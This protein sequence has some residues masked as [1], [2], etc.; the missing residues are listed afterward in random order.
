MLVFVIIVQRH[1]A[2]IHCVFGLM[3]G[4]QMPAM[5]GDNET[6][7]LL[8]SDHFENAIAGRWEQLKFGRPTEYFICHEANSNCLKA[9]AD[10]TC[11]ALMTKVQLEPRPRLIARWRWK[12]DQ[13]P[14]NS[15]DHLARSFDHTARV[16]IAFDTFIGPPRTV[17]Y[18]WANQVKIGDVFPHPK[19]GRAQMIALESGDNKAGQ[20]ISE[21]RDVTADWH[22]LFGDKAMPSIVAVGVITDSESTGTKVTGYYQN[23]ELFSK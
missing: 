5:A 21:E 1:L 11:S 22:Q 6:N 14:P 17:N 10:N 18:V 16:I 9:V 8:F 23:I 4:W 12:I 7:T 20:W 13:I 3:V 15:T 19:S 2:V